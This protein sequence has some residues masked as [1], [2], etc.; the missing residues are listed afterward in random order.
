M[1]KSSLF[2]EENFDKFLQIYKNIN[3]K[4]DLISNLQDEYKLENKIKKELN[5]NIFN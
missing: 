2:L 3:I 1:K 5:I 4:E